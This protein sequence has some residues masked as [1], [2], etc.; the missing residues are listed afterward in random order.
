MTTPPRLHQTRSEN[1]RP[2]LYL[3]I[4]RLALLAVVVALVPLAARATTGDAQRDAHAD[5]RLISSHNAVAPGQTVRLGVHFEL[6]PKWHIYW[7]NPGEAGMPTRI[8]WSAGPDLPVPQPV[9][10]PS[11]FRFVDPYG[12]VGFGYEGR[13]VFVAE[14]TAPDDWAGGPVAFTAKT[15]YLACADICIPGNVEA[16]LTLPAASG[17]DEAEVDA[18][19]TALIGDALLRQAGSIDG[20][21]Y[22][23][24]R[25]EGG[26]VI[27]EA[28]SPVLTGWIADAHDP[29][30]MPA[31]G[32]V[33]APKA[34][35]PFARIAD[36]AGGEVVRLTL[37]PAPRA[38]PERIAGL[39]QLRPDLAKSEDLLEEVGAPISV[40]IDVA[41]ADVS[42]AWAAGPA[43][44]GPPIVTGGASPLAPVSE[45]AADSEGL[46]AE[47]LPFAAVL[48]LSALAGVVLNI[49][50]CVFPV[51]AI[52]VMGFVQQAGESRRKVLAHGGVFAVGVIVSFWAMGA[53]VIGLAQAGE[54]VGGQGF[55]LARPEFVAAMALLLV[56]L[57]LNFLGVFDV[58]MGVM[59][60]A[61]KASTKVGG[62]YA[63][64]FGA[65]LLTTALSTPCAA[66][67][68]ALNSATALAYGDSAFDTLAIFTAM[69]VGLALPV[70]LLSAFPAWLRA[71]PKPGMWMERF[72]QFMAFPMFVVALWL[73]SVFASLT[74]DSGFLRL[75]VGLVVAAMGLWVWGAFGGASAAS[76]GRA[77]PRVKPFAGFAALL[78]LAGAMVLAIST[79]VEELDAV[80]VAFEPAE[81]VFVANDRI[82]WHPYSA[83]AV[84]AFRNAGRPVFIDFTADWCANCKAMEKAFIER[85]AVSDA[86]LEL[87]VAMVKADWTR[88]EQNKPVTEALYALGFK[89]VPVY[90]MYPADPEAQPDVVQAFGSAEQVVEMMRRAAAASPDPAPAPAV[91][92]AARPDGPEI[93]A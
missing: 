52:K 78:G 1:V 7:T 60:A 85:A 16:S 5:V 90:A 47:P 14:W 66:P 32:G 56:A 34:E 40:P 26:S 77:N 70:F 11:P 67:F 35:Q 15:A 19:S 83:E 84:E 13:A 38:T 81:V 63:G 86:V 88:M 54:A 76:A 4:G 80:G 72:R 21:E 24:W 25:G 69:G 3:Q 53:V 62:G 41:V 75:S 49:M 18:A 43:V 39:L 28:R 82:Q 33:L 46:P 61:G 91:V 20:A 10:W 71:L 36:D 6:D 64:S 8:E 58:G 44:Q 93:P 89:S 87:N 9:A 12:T 92:E 23:A 2:R 37:T 59:S 42:G 74:S 79:P 51:L 22:R 45:G 55:L 73:V 48:G 27:L 50:P 57:G 68:V 29:V 30:V 65:G 31:K 17:A